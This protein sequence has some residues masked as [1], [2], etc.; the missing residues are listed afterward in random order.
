MRV[1]FVSKEATISKKHATNRMDGMKHTSHAW[2]ND[3]ICPLIMHG[4]M[5]KD[6]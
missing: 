3:D 2:I 4:R 5:K 1:E 6:T